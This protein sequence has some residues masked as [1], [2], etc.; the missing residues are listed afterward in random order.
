MAVPIEDL[1]VRREEVLNKYGS[2][3]KALDALQNLDDVETGNYIAALENELVHQ[4][5]LD[6]GTGF[7]SGYRSDKPLTPEEIEQV[8]SI[9]NKQ[10]RL[11]S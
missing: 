6:K 1:K 9:D 10:W 3:G 5:N 8:F 2:I 7:V 11:L 4:Y